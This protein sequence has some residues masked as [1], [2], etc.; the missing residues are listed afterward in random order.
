V[1]CRVVLVGM[2]NENTFGLYSFTKIL[3]SFTSAIFYVH[4]YGILNFRTGY[5]ANVGG[6]FG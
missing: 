5:N 4:L 3:L 6:L 1:D 2:W